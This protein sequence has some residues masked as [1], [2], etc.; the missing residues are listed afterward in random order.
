[1][2][3]TPPTTGHTRI[4]P[5]ASDLLTRCQLLLSELETFK[6]YLKTRKQDSSVEIAHFRNT[7]KSEHR[8]LSRLA[9][10]EDVEATQHTVNSSNLPFLEQ[11]WGVVK[12]QTGLQAMQK[13]FY[14][15]EA[16]QKRGM[17]K[18]NS[19]LVD[20]VA[21][22]GLKW[23][24]VSLL[25]NNRLLFDKAKQGWEDASSSEEED[26]D[27]EEQTQD[28][29]K[30]EDEDN[31]VPL[32]KMTKDLVRAAKEVKIRT[33]SPT[34]TLVL[35]KLRE[36][37]VA[38]IDK[39]LDQLRALGVKLLTSTSISSPPPFNTVMPH[40]LTNPFASFTP[41]LNIDCTILLA[42][43]SDFSHCSVTTEPWFH[44]ALTRQVEIEDEENLLPNL[45]YPALANAE[46]SVFLYGWDRGITTIT[47]NRTVV[48][49]IENVLAKEAGGEGE[50]PRVWLCPTARS[51][52]GKEKGRRD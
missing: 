13:R 30:E 22:D 9:D 25:T 44:R 45:L 40:L 42:L 43:V 34:I 4:L 41:T 12:G 48:K 29:K 52:V 46:L 36:G 51:L 11:V 15:Q 47:S 39:I 18:R 31:D 1:M 32:V 50:W 27:G 35:P 28:G 26:E 49:Q 8:T 37:E 24:K 19:A 38:E 21:G 2:T 3:D 33:R 14:W 16:G 5:T 7:V 23:F 10:N 20:I 17:K 6:E